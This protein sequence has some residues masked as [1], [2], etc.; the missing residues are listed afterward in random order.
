M[1]DGRYRGQKVGFGCL[2][3]FKN[4]GNGNVLCLKAI[5]DALEERK[6]IKTMLAQESS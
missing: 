2:F 4:V 3:V 1:L 6:T 5:G